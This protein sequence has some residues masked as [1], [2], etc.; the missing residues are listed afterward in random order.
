MIENQKL[1]ELNNL[2]ANLKLNQAY[3]TVK[4]KEDY[5]IEDV[6][7]ELNMLK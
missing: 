1:E 2:W 4:F 3:K 5:T 7:R 6:Q